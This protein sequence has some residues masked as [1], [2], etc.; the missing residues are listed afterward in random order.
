MTALNFPPS[1]TD[2][3]IFGNYRWDATIGVWRLLPEAVPSPT[4]AVG[5]SRTFLLMGA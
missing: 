4:G 1:P 3:Q 2:G 5:F